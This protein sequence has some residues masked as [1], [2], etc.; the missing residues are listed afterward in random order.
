MHD[1]IAQTTQT[2]AIDRLGNGWSDQAP[3]LQASEQIAATLHDLLVVQG[4]EPPY[5]LAGHSAGGV[6]VRSFAAA[7]PDEVM[8]M[9]LVDSGHEAHHAQLSDWQVEQADG[10][11]SQLQLCSRTAPFG[12]VRQLGIAAGFTEVLKLD[13]DQSVQFGAMFNQTHFCAASLDE[14][15]AFA[16]DTDEMRAP[17]SLGAL[18]L[19]VL[20]RGVGEAADF[21]AETAPS[22]VTLADVEAADARWRDN[23]MELATLSSNS[24]LIIA[25]E[26]R[27]FIQA[28]Q[29][30]LVIEAVTTLLE[31]GR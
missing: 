10:I 8:G 24:Q 18:P 23:Q 11:N 4:I 30:E 9:L 20:A 2:C 17:A 25:E 3:S 6:H 27:H 12:L 21:S 31:T 16:A 28:D 15:L 5:L 29:P 26:S 22:S 13:A 14:R 1:D 19:V 7:Y